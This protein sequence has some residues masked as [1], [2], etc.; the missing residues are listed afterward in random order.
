M[1][2]DPLFALA[3]LAA[4]APIRAEAATSQLYSLGTVYTTGPTYT[5]DGTTY[6]CGI[7]SG[8]N[9]TEIAS[10]VLRL[11]PQAAKFSLS[12]PIDYK[13]YGGTY[14]YEFLYGSWA[15]MTFTSNSAGTIKF[16]QELGLPPGILDKGPGKTFHFENFRSI[17]TPPSYRF[18][19]DLMIP[20][21]K[22]TLYGSY[23][24]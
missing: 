11:A 22:M 19:F 9:D 20:N 2:R 21:C 15:I 18:Q 5:V 8:P 7:G 16:D 13:V 23:Q 10:S 4:L 24:E 12:L 3:L 17:L 6:T 1:M 14:Q